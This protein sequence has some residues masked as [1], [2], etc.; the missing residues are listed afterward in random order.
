MWLWN[1]CQETIKPPGKEKSK[2][3]GKLLDGVYKGMIL[4][5][6]LNLKISSKFKI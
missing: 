6:L 4:F 2:R 3:V 1:D 5:A